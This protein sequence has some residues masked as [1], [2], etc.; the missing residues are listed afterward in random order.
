MG[1]TLCA[2]YLLVFLLFRD[3]D[4]A[5][6]AGLL[7]ALTPE[8]L[9]WSATAA[10]EPSASLALA[11]SVVCA[12]YYLRAGGSLPLGATVVAAAYALQFR[13]ESLLILPVIGF[14]IWPRLRPEV[15]RPA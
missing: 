7:I 12:A 2:V 5:F 1:L 6:F 8:Q 9:L 4:A 10:V 3:R 11:A 15:D 13:P 14:L